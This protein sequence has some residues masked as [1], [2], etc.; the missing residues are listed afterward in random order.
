MSVSIVDLN[1]LDIEPPALDTTSPDT[2]VWSDGAQG[3][4]AFGAT[5]G[6]WHWLR[7]VGAGS[8]R[9]P[10]RP[11]GITIAAEVVPEAD[12]PRD[13]IIDAYYRS[14]VPLALQAY[15]FETLHGS[16]VA[17]PGGVVAMCADRE[18]GKSTIAYALQRRGHGAVADDSVVLSIP[19]APVDT[20][21]EVH[22][23]PFELR[24]R[25]PTAQ[26]FEQPDKRTVRVDGASNLPATDDLHLAAIVMLS[27]HSE[28]G[29]VTLTRLSANEAFMQVLSQSFAFTLIQGDRKREMMRSYLRL[30]NL[31]PVHRLS[32]PTG[33]E[34]LDAICDRIEAL[35]TELPR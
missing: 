11:S 12:A 25:T 22:A 16:G 19:H 15:G 35:G 20:R 29:P 23:L 33:L 21:V 8:Y 1:F 27:R 30:V 6:E 4:V 18:T 28:P 24:L 31:V 9:F 5:R 34:H 32:Y 14:I 7:L 17:L 26:H 3:P 2:T 13:L 10:V